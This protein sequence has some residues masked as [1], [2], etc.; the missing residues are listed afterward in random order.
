MHEERRS[1]I[2]VPHLIGA[3]TV[4]PGEVLTFEEEMDGGGGRA[5]TGESGRECFPSDDHIGTIRLAIVATLGVRLE[6]Q[7]FN[8][9]A[10]AAHPVH[11]NEQSISGAIR[12]ESDDESHATGC[13]RGQARAK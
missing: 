7:L 6:L 8:P 4:K 1:G 13:G 3:Q 12:A 2:E 10:R 9:E 5:W 11:G